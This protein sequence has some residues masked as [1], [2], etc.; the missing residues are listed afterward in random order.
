MAPAHFLNSSFTVSHNAV[1]EASGS[2]HLNE[3]ACKAGG[4]EDEAG[5][6]AARECQDGFAEEA[7]LEAERRISFTVPSASATEELEKG[8][9]AGV[10]CGCTIRS[11]HTGYYIIVYAVFARKNPRTEVARRRPARNLPLQL[12]EECLYLPSISFAPPKRSLHNSTSPCCLRKAW[13]RHHVTRIPL[14]EVG[15]LPRVNTALGVSSAVAY[16]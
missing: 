13:R 16:L 15:F 3:A 9:P 7:D 11:V 8:G 5:C 1:E 4:T 2:S 6:P 12:C 10:S 14:G